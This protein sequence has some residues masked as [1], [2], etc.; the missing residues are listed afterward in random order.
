MTT[1]VVKLDGRLR[2]WSGSDET[3][4]PYIELDLSGRMSPPQGQYW[5]VERFRMTI[6]NTNDNRILN[7]P[8][9]ANVRLLV[10]R[11][12]S[13]TVVELYWTTREYNWGGDPPLN[14]DLPRCILRLHPGFPAVVP[15]IGDTTSTV[16]CGVLGGESAE[17][18]VAMIGTR[19]MATDGTGR[20]LP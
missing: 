16:Y 14:Y 15:A 20:P 17:L 7:A 6:N 13:Q 2:I 10:V 12:L 9:M 11:N 8:T 1:Q 5:T 19:L 4:E 3:T 18:E